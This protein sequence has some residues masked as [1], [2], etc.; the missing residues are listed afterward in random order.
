MACKLAHVLGIDKKKI[1]NNQ[2]SIKQNF[3]FIQTSITE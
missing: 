1:S 2:E 3:E